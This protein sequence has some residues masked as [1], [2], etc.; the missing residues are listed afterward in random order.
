MPCCP[1]A[2]AWKWCSTAIWVSAF[3]NCLELF[4]MLRLFRRRTAVSRPALLLRFAIQPELRLLPRAGDL[5]RQ[6]RARAGLAEERIYWFQN[7]ALP[8]G[9]RLRHLG[10]QPRHAVQIDVL[11]IDAVAPLQVDRRPRHLEGESGKCDVAVLHVKPAADRR[12][13]V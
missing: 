13:H 4:L 7:E 8:A 9:H 2:L 6:Q 11:R 3:R 5:D 10:L 1:K 12:Q